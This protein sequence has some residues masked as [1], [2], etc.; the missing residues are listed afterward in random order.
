[1]NPSQRST[2]TDSINRLL[3][4]SAVLKDVTL[5][6]TAQKTRG[7]PKGALNKPRTTNWD[8]SGFEILE[9]KRKAEDQQEE[10]KKK[11]KKTEDTKQT[12]T[13]NLK[14]TDEPPKKSNLKKTDKPAPKITPPARSTSCRRNSQ[15][16]AH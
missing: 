14:K 13:S 10:K 12:K 11:L 3:D 7:R 4:G 8:P 2:H 6:K 5:P 9:K 16:T 15:P 1:M